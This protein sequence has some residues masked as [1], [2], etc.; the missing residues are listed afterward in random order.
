ML[1]IIYYNMM[2]FISGGN[3]ACK[4]S[5]TRK[6]S[7]LYYDHSAEAAVTTMTCSNWNKPTERT[8]AVICLQSIGAKPGLCGA[9]DAEIHKKS[10]MTQKLPKS[11]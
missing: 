11:F 9:V 4:C 2:V 8:C 10:H 1:F 6:C 7:C 3:P 5:F